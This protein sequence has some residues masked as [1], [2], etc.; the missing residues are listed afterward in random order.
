MP[1]YMLSL[2]VDPIDVSRPYSKLPL[3]CT[4]LQYFEVP[5]KFSGLLHTLSEATRH[6]GP[7]ILRAGGRD[8]FGRDRTIPV[9]LVK[10]ARSIVAL[11]RAVLRAVN[12]ISGA[13]ICDPDW[14]GGGVIGRTSA[15]S[16]N[17]RWPEWPRQ[18]RTKSCSCVNIPIRNTPSPASIWERPRREDGN[19]LPPLL[20]YPLAT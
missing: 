4:L 11:H 8:M 9:T 5:E 1:T 10:P 17:A 18:R 16:A 6:R 7:V 19:A 14:A 2:P 13:V 3:H 20:A 15:T 12:D